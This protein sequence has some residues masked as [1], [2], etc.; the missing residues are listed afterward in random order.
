MK[1][2]DKLRRGVCRDGMVKEVLV[3]RLGAGKRAGG[4]GEDD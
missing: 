3:A 2:R 1:E 4:D